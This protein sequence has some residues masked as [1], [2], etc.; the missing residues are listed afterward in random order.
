MEYFQL[1]SHPYTVIL[2]YILLRYEHTLSFLTIYLYRLTANHINILS[3]TFRKNTLIIE[4][5]KE[6]LNF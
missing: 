2:S 1:T 5:D 4:Y 3:W 6:I